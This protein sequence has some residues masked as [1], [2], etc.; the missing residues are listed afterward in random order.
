MKNHNAKVGGGWLRFVRRAYG[1]FLFLV[2]IDIALIVS[3]EAMRNALGRVDGRGW[4]LLASRV[5]PSLVLLGF[6]SWFLSRGI[7]SI[8]ET[9]LASALHSAVFSL[10]GLA[11]LLPWLGLFAAVLTP[12]SVVYFGAIVWIPGGYYVASLAALLFTGVNLGIGKVAL[13]RYRE[14]SSEGGA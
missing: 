3:S 4:M 6:Y 12:I 2:I 14:C 1:V 9:A 11:A 8:R 13:A 10:L 7:R 5:L